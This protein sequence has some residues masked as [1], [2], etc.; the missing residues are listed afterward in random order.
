MSKIREIGKNLAVPLAFIILGALSRLLPHLP[1]ATPVGALALFSGFYLPKK[2]A[3]LVPLLAMAAAD[4]F[5][6][7][8]STLLWVYGSFLLIVA[9]GFLLKGRL[10]AENV[11]LASLSSSIL[12][13]LITNFGVWASTSMYSKDLAGLLQSYVMG[14]PFLRPT[15]LGDLFYSGVIFGSYALFF[16]RRK[17]EARAKTAIKNINP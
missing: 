3:F 16:L 4:L 5:L 8:H 2:Q 15:V 14:I 11:I 17:E 13:F 12:F 9:L 1:N 7:G 10:K 6:G